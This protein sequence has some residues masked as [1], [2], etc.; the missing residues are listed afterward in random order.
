M[1]SRKIIAI[2]YLV[3]GTKFYFEWLLITNPVS[4]NP[5]IKLFWGWAKES[6][7]AK[8]PS[9]R[10]RLAWGLG[11]VHM[12]LGVG[13]AAIDG[14][15][16]LTNLLVNFYPIFVQIYIGYRCWSV[17]IRKKKRVT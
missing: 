17:I 15:I 10:L 4:K 8:D 13:F 9:T 14:G 12:W 11:L 3:S 5:A 2:L 16:E 1:F 6:Y 7:T